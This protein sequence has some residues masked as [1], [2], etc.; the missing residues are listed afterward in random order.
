LYIMRLPAADPHTG[1][2]VSNK[3][4]PISGLYLAAVAAI[5][6]YTGG[7]LLTRILRHVQESCRPEACFGQLFHKQR[8]R[9]A[10]N[11]GVHTFIKLYRI[12]HD[13]HCQS[14]DLIVVSSLIL[15]A[16]HQLSCA[17]TSISGPPLPS[18]SSRLRRQVFSL[19]HAKQATLS[20]ATFQLLY[21]MLQVQNMRL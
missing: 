17:Y 12:E 8:D 1:F 7:N 10:Q 6:S 16:S 14:C 4:Q 13:C 9:K 18:G 2:H 21:S 3:D 20:T 11:K 5:D 15:M 19:G